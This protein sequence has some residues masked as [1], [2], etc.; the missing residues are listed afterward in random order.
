MLVL[1]CFSALN[2]RAQ[3][4]SAPDEL[5][6]SPT[7][8]KWEAGI[9]GV[10]F[11]VPDYPAS[12]DSST[13]AL[14]LPYFVYK[15]HTLRDSDDGS[16]MR[17]RLSP[18]VELDVSGSGSLATDSSPSDFRQG[19]PD[20]GYLLEV[21]PNLRLRFNELTPGSTWILN[22]PVRAVLSLDHEELNWRGAVFAPEVAWLAL[23]ALKHRFSLRLSAGL[24]YS[25]APLQRYFY[26]VQ[27]QYATAA[28]PAYEADAGYMGASLG[29]RS[30]Y[31][32]SKRFRGFAAAR[33][34]R[35]DG[36]A[37]EESPLFRSDEGYLL[38]VG[39]I[40]T[41]ARS[42]QKASD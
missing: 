35:Y 34:Y 12:D 8:P 42:S 32:F 6:E 23:P 2:A 11:D 19:M 36:A 20:L 21:G 9:A 25:A 10:A 41:L 38:G 5:T 30:S 4:V 14:P 26:E 3:S 7:R 29:I 33:Y 1:L 31:A 28:R 16:Q 40:W 13:T 15:G 24:E 18:N 27:P 37:N 39:F 17:H 22:L